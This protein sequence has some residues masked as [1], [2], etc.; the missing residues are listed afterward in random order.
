MEDAALCGLYPPGWMGGGGGVIPPEGGRSVL[1][2]GSKNRASE[3]GCSHNKLPDNK[4]ARIIFYYDFIFTP[5]SDKEL[6][7]TLR[8]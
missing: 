4:F 7:Q 2:R 8:D 3:R 6:C 5:S 1:V